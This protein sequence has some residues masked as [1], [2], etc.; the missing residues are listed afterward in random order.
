MRTWGLVVAI[1]AQR[2]GAGRVG[3]V[4]IEHD[5]IRFELA[6]QRH[7][8]GSVLGLAHH[9]HAGALQHV[10]QSFAKEVVVVREDDAQSIA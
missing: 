3:H 8:L 4:E 7:R 2:L 9:A 5:Q 10:A 1:C 6:R